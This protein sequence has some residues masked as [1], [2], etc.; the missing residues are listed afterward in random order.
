MRHPK[1]AVLTS[2]EIGEKISKKKN[3]DVFSERERKQALYAAKF[4]SISISTRKNTQGGWTIF[5]F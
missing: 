5:F 4:S 2:A 1:P 3:F